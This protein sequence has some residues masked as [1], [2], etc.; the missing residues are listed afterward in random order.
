LT[1]ASLARHLFK[2]KTRPNIARG[3]RF[4]RTKKFWTWMAFIAD[5]V[6]SLQQIVRDAL[7]HDRVVLVFWMFRDKTSHPLRCSQVLT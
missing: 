2:L 5:F 3:K 4:W 7:A 1:I 6:A